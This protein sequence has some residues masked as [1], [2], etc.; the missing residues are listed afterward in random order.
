MAHP[1]EESS[2]FIRPALDRLLT[3]VALDDDRLVEKQSAALLVVAPHASA[4]RE[5]GG[6]AEKNAERLQRLLNQ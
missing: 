6:S 1:M 4:L 3:A 5:G 2:Q